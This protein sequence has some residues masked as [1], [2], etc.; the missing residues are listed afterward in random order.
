MKLFLRTTSRYSR[1]STGNARLM[2]QP[3]GGRRELGGGTDLVDE[4]LLERGRRDREARDRDPPERR[5]QHPLRVGTRG[6]A[7]L[8]AA[9]VEP[10]PRDAGETG[11]E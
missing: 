6:Q 1:L 3:P 4:D 8:G 9:S 7:Q 5:R 10:G 2:T 11:E